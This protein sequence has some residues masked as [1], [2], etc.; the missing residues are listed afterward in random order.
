[1]EAGRAQGAPVKVTRLGPADWLMYRDVRLAALRDAPYAFSSKWEKEV[2]LGQEQWQQR[3]STRSQFVALVEGVVVG[4]IGGIVLPDGMAA[5]LIS[6]WVSPA[7]RGR[8]VGD[9]LVAAVLD[10][11]AT[12]GLGEVRLWV[13]SGNGAAERLYSRC[14]FTRT[15]AE[16]LVRPDEPQTEFEMARS[17]S[18]GRAQG[19]PI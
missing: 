9:R 14:G 8:G 19:A 17:V 10:W 6:M 11:A 15:G 13:T 1:M 5:E 4:T 2:L 18:A 3:L 7:A 16:Q 12:A